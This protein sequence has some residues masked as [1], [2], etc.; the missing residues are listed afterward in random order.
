MF[1]R[2]L[3]DGGWRH[4]RERWRNFREEI[5]Q[6][7][8]A[9]EI[10]LVVEWSGGPQISLKCYFGFDEQSD[11]IILHCTPDLNYLTLCETS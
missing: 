3:G 5:Q 10:N 8:R 4:G 2:E 1:C 11:P 9:N 6:S 7:F